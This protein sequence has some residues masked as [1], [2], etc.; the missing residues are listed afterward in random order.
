AL[1]VR[2]ADPGVCVFPGGSL[3]PGETP[4]DAVVRE[5]WEET[6][7]RVEPVA[8]RGIF[9]GP[10]F[11]VRY[12]NGDATTYVMS[13]FECRVIG[14]RARPDGDETLELRWVG[15]DELDGLE[16]AAWVR[17]VAPAVFGQRPAAAFTPATWLPPG[18]AR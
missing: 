6:G 14:G 17:V 11:L 7:L 5:T 8:L 1:V 18:D 10:D 16:I 15:R 4:A 3:D 13:V 12:A 9:G 2:A